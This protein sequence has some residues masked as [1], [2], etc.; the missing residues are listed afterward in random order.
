M[1]IPAGQVG[2][3]TVTFV[4]TR[5]LLFSIDLLTRPLSI[6]SSLV[7]TLEG[8]YH[9]PWLPFIE[10][11]IYTTYDLDV[12][13]AQI[14]VT[15]I[16]DFLPSVLS[17]LNPSQIQSDLVPTLQQLPTNTLNQLISSLDTSNPLCAFFHC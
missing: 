15:S 17:V 9:L 5:G 13:G 12:L 1:T 10:Y 6:A 11:D 3:A 2:I 8:G 4:M 14:N 16:A 7:V